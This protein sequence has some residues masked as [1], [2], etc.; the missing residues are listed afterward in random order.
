M[1]EEEEE[2]LG[3]RHSQA[4]EPGEEYGE[5]GGTLLSRLGR[6]GPGGGGAGELALYQ[7]GVPSSCFVLVLQARVGRRGAARPR[8]GERH[9]FALLCRRRR[10]CAC[11]PGRGRGCLGCRGAVSAGLLGRPRADGGAGRGRQGKV[12]ACQAALGL[13]AAR[14]AVGRARWWP[15]RPPQG[16]RGAANDTLYRRQGKV[17]V[18][19]GTEGFQSEQGPWS[20]LGA[21]ALRGGGKA[22]PYV[23]DFDAVTAGSCR[24][25]RVTADAYAAALRMG[26]AAEGRA[27]DQIVGVR[28]VQQA[29]RPAAPA[30]PADP[31]ASAPHV[32]PQRAC[33]LL[34][35]AL[36]RGGRARAARAAPH[37]SVLRAAQVLNASV[38][39]SRSAGNLLDVQRLDAAAAPARSA[40][41]APGGAGR[42]ASAALA[43]R[44]SSSSAGAADAG[45]GGFELPP[46]P[47]GS[48]GAAGGRAGGAGAGAAGA[49]AGAFELVPRGAADVAGA[50]A[51]GPSLGGR[52]DSS[53]DTTEHA[54]L[55]PPQRGL[56]GD[57]GGPRR[58]G[59]SHTAGPPPP[60]S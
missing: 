3:T 54:P 26:R 1:D 59:D 5:R 20:Y 39:L 53:S 55:V 52:D 6:P 40:A 9:V 34:R 48:G 35:G 37:H 44:T 19:A 50:R 45:A 29:R 17:V 51:G 15:A 33:A 10:R 28:A 60:R 24:L 7:R 4:P 12:V 25:L 18:R 21:K 30:P 27:A 47:R 57:R 23:P 31:A 42:G 36:C 46:A 13:A 49:G 11:R 43:P 58:P 41:A 16:C 14:G 38:P 22:G 32:A 56:G 2:D 8:A